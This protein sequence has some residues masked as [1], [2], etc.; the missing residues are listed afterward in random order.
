MA[1]Q[2]PPQAARVGLRRFSPS[3]APAP[4]PACRPA[5]L[6]STQEDPIG[7]A[8]GLNLYG[9]AGADPINSSDPFGLCPRITVSG[10]EVLIEANLETSG[11]SPADATR[12]AKGIESIWG[13][14]RGGKNVKVSL[15]VADAPLVEVF[16]T[17]NPG[18]QG[19]SRGYLAGG[20]MMVPVGAGANTTLTAAA[21]EFGHVMGLGHD[22]TG[23]NLMNQSI[24][25]GSAFNRR[26]SPSQLQQA[27]QNCAAPPTEN[28]TED[29]SK[30]TSKS[31]SNP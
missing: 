24:H 15:A 4:P 13:G 23:N 2:R 27:I 25:A 10:N 8:G 31:N 17:Q 14:K 18:G 11:L 9:Y 21:H 29:T 16:T 30:S 26:I 22:G 6:Y 3:S 5:T 19:G 20:Q 28:S 7:L 12:V 1:V